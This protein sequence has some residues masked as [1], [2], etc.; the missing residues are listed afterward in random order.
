MFRAE[1]WGLREPCTNPCLGIR[2]NP[3]NKVARFLDTD[4]FARLGRALAANEVR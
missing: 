2:R 1:E 4:G 3:R